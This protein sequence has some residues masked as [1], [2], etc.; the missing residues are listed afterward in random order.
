M[1]G[2]QDAYTFRS[3]KEIRL[4]SNFGQQNAKELAE[5]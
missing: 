1:T 2:W 5:T 3:S 4:I